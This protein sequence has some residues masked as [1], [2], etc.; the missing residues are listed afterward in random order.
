[1][2]LERLTQ[3]WHVFFFADRSPLPLAVFRISFGVLLF[4]YFLTAHDFLKLYFGSGGL[5]Q[6]NPLAHSSGILMWSLIRGTGPRFFELFYGITLLVILMFVTGY[7]TRISSVSLWVLVVSWIN[8]LSLGSNHADAIIR[9]LTFPCMVAGL[10]G[11]LQTA[12]SIDCFLATRRRGNS[13]DAAPRPIPAWSTRLFQVQLILIYFFSGWSK[14]QAPDWVNGVAMH[15]VVNQSIWARFDLSWISLSPTFVGLLTY[16]TLLFELI[17]FPV[18]VWPRATRIPALMAGLLF[19]F[20]IGLSLRIIM[21]TEVMPVF[22]LVFLERE[23]LVFVRDR[24][25]RSLK[26]QAL[27][28]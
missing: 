28:E 7:L 9:L 6:S 18:L 19:H 27:R 11:H 26:G 17:L 23:H 21:F 12:V 5:L 24:L 15:Y 20:G 13:H 14:S 16:G 3:P 2:K 22:Y 8:P 1:M 25:R 4:C 10:A